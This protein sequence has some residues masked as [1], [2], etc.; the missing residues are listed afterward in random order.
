MGRQVELR[1]WRVSSK[2]GKLAPDLVGGEEA[3]K[4][5]EKER[6]IQL[7]SADIDLLELGLETNVV[8]MESHHSH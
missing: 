7:C 3:L 1:T 8:G 4:G 2:A 6:S 5:R